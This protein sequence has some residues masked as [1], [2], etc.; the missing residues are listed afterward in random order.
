MLAY[1]VQ[2]GIA[3][4]SEKDANRPLT[5]LGKSETLRIATHLKTHGVKIDHVFH[6]GKQRAAETAIIFATVLNNSEPSRLS[7]MKANDEPRRLI[8][9]IQNE[10]SMF[11]G[12]LPNIQRVVS[13]L[14]TGNDSVNTIKFSNSAVACIEQFDGGNQLKWFL[15]ADLC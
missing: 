7:G 9:Q 13:K 12:H 14:L 6:S 11:V 2:H 1:F 15:T 5:E 10:N 8:D 4:S 3:E